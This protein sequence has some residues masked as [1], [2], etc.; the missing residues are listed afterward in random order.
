VAYTIGTTKRVT[1]D[2]EEGWS[3]T[4]T[5]DEN[6]TAEIRYFGDGK[7]K[8]RISIP[9]DGIPHFIDALRDLM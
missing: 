1:I 2:H 9:K 7:E 8:Q 5:S 4:L 6:G 3:Y